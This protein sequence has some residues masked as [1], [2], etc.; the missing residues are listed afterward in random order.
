MKEKGKV[1]AD[2]RRNA[3]E[4][5]IREGDTVLVKQDRENKLS[6][7][8]AKT[9]VKVVSKNGNS[10]VVESGQGVRYQ[11]NVT[12]VKKFVES[13]TSGKPVLDH[14]IMSDTDKYDDT[15]SETQDDLSEVA[16][17]FSNSNKTNASGQ[18]CSAESDK[19]VVRP[20]RQI[21]LPARFSDYVIGHK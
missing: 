9:P 7:P 19:P 4:S 18:N 11:R 6:T 16:L 12:R 10:V 14:T 8:F 5:D 3:C 15:D 2:K 1:Y 21:N 20:R 13:N 17:E